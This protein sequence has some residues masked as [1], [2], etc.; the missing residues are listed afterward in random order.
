MTL[1]SFTLLLTHSISFFVLVKS[2]KIHVLSLSLKLLLLK[3][4]TKIE[5]NHPILYQI[6]SD[7]KIWKLNNIDWNTVYLEDR[8][9]RR[10][11]AASPPTRRTPRPD[12]KWFIDQ[13]CTKERKGE[14]IGKEER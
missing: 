9:R 4:L 1:L 5:R 3:W 7:L 8:T 11:C 6:I 10:D 13:W 14:R 2:F 12:C